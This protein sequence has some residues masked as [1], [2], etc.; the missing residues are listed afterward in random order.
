MHRLH[1]QPLRSGRRF[2]RLVCRVHSLG[3]KRTHLLRHRFGRRF[4]IRDRWQNHLQLAGHPYTRRRRQRTTRRNGRARCR[5]APHRLFPLRGARQTGVAANLAPQGN[6]GRPAAGTGQRV[7]QIR[8]SRHRPHRAQR[9]PRLRGDPRNQRAERLFLDRRYAPFPFH[10][11]LFG[12]G[13]G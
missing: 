3:Q 2:L 8:R 5:A 13:S 11:L 7:R 12:T 9:R 6:N 4:R 10:A 1:G